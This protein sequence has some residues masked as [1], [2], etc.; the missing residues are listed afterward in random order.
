[1]L[2]GL[3][4]LEFLWHWWQSHSLWKIWKWVNE[5]SS[6]FVIMVEG[7]AI[8]EFALSGLVELFARHG[9]VVRVNG[10]QCGFSE[11]GWQRLYSLR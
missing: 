2:I 4:I 11:V 6:F 9:L 3:V 8:A 1:M 7:A 5:L 10:S